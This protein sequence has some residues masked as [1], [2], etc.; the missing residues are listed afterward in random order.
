MKV[1]VI[2]NYNIAISNLK[3]YFFLF[4]KLLVNPMLLIEKL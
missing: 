1:I 3:K 2:F 4:Y